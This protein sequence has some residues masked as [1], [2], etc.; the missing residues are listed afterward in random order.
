MN[1]LIIVLSVIG[2][3]GL[4]YGIPELLGLEKTKTRITLHKTNISFFL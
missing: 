3:I 4:F 2:F 1:I